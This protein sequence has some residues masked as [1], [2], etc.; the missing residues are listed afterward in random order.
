MS[1]S[2]K[3]LGIYRIESARL[4]NYDYSQPGIYYITI[5][6]KNHVLIFGD[7]IDSKMTLSNE[8]NIAKKYWVD[9]P[10]HY[11]QIELDEYVI[12][13]NHIH[14]LIKIIETAKSNISTIGEIINNYKRTCTLE[15]RK[16]NLEFGWQTRFY[17]HIVREYDDLDRIRDYIRDNPAKWRQDELFL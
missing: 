13:P 2:E 17:D 3:Y 11:H 6:T 4:K 10:N 14:G 15:I 7:V 9:I 12:M 16:F 5:C 8:G 1:D